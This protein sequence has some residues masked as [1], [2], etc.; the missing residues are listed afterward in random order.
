MSLD[1]NCTS[2]SF[3]I[4]SKRVYDVIK[5]LDRHTLYPQIRNSATAEMM[6]VACGKIAGYVFLKPEPFDIAAAGLIVERAGGEVTEADG[7]PWGP[8][9]RSLVASNG[10][11]HNDL[12][13]IIKTQ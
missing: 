1:K 7:N 10:A 12:L 8:F 6:M 4:Q 13:R 11:I 5:I 3:V 2:V 9:S